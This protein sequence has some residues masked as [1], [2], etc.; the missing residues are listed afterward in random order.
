MLFP[1]V[2]LLGGASM[3]GYSLVR[4]YGLGAL[5]PYCSGHSRHAACREWPRLDLDDADA[6]RRV[7][8][9]E[10]PDLVLHCGGICDVDKCE[11]QPDFAWAI[12]VESVGILLDALA[13]STRLVYCSSDHVFGAGPGPHPEDAPCRPIS[14]YGRTRLAAERLIGARRADALIVRHGIGI[15]PSIGGRT[16]H[17]DWL[18]YRT[19]RGL[20]T[21]VIA[22][23]IRSA[24]WAEDL[25]ERVWALAHAAVS[26][27][28]HVVAT[29][30]VNRV[31]LAGYLND[32]FSIGADLSFA[33]RREQAAPHIGDV[34]LATSHA[35]RLARPLRAVVPVAYRSGR[36]QGVKSWH[37]T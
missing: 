21:T 12:N 23:E 2:I 11:A 9:I 28:R 10:Q 34:A 4:R 3:L 19:K 15:G 31:Q 24:V 22:D 8:A 35:D 1:K 37:A 20:P 36:A 16:G 32:R 29:A 5:T 25:A 27:V 18:R 7:I 26:G 30:P 33:G 17:L 14:V 13:P 6:I